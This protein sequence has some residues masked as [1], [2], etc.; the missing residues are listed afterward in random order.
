M[1]PV[2]QATAQ[3]VRHDGRVIPFRPGLARR[4]P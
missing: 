3:V 4:L 1:I 2:L